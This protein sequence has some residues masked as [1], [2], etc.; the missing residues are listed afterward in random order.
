MK[1]SVYANGKKITDKILLAE[2]ATEEI[3]VFESVRTYAGKIFRL[4]EHLAR[5]LESAKTAGVRVPKDPGRL[6][7]ELELALRAFYDE[8]GKKESLFL[9]ITLWR[10]QIF[11]MAGERKHS[12]LLYRR[13]VALR[14]SSC[15]RNLSNAWAPEAKTSAYQNAV[16]AGLGPEA[17]KIYEWV[18]LDQN[19]FVTEVRIGNLFIVKAGGLKTPPEPGILNGVTRRF[20]IECSFRAGIPVSEVPLTRHEIFTAD[21]AFLTN[22]SWEILPVAELD[23]RRIGKAVPGPVIRKLQKIFRKRMKE[24]CR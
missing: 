13:G 7:R 24:E 2:F 19:G 12:A 14:T 4:E 16:L 10:D 21:E 22:T 8:T 5:L 15:P 3:G 11:V 1:F 18:F 23:G 20:V 17:E 9:R 6:R